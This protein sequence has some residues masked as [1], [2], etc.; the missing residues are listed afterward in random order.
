VSQRYLRAFAGFGIEIEYMIVD[1]RTLD[2]APVADRLL[3]A[4]AGEL[5][6]ETDQGATCWSNELVLHVVEIKTNG[7][8]ASLDGIAVDFQAA[9][10]RINRLLE[11]LHACLLPGGAHPWMDPHTQTRLWPHDANEVYAAYDRIFGCAGHGWSNLQSMHINLPF[12]DDAEFARLHAAIR[13]VLPLLPALAASTPYL[14]GRSTGL[15]DARIDAYAKN[16]ARI[17]EITGRIVP[18]PASSASEYETRILQPMYRAIAPHD[19]DGTLAHEWLNSRGAIARFDRQ[20]IE[21]RL[22]DNQEAPVADLAVAALVTAT[23]RRLYDDRAALDTGNALDTEQLATILRR[24]V[25]AAEGAIID[26]PAYLAVLG[27]A[28][29]AARAGSV[30]RELAKHVEA[31]VAAHR[32]VLDVIFDEGTLASRLQRAVGRDVDRARLYATYARLRD[33]LANGQMFTAD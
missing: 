21:I 23:V 27:V 33:C 30:W 9:V 16:Q 31:E 14:E 15:A 24:C 2:V 8:R 17:P 26:E 7:P 4:A 20:T 13:L 1:R 19:A 25:A 28:T 5:T 10:G 6:D 22:L 12:A 11:P 32:G 18:E 29:T 3:T